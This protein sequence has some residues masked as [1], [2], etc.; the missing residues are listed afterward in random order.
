MPPSALRDRKRER[1]RRALQE[2]AVELF[3]SRGYEATTVADI[4]AA[5][6]V[7]TRT[8]FNYF[9][10]K[11][12][13]LFPE[14]DERVSAAAHAVATRRPDERPVEVL[15]RA[16]RAAGDNPGDHL[17]DNLASRIAVLRAKVSRTVPAVSGRAAHAQLAAQM[18]IA[19]HL[20][21]A[22]PD[23]LDEVEAAALVGAVVG[24]VSGALTALFAHPAGAA[25]PDRL[26]RQI[27]EVTNKVL[28]PWLNP[29]PG[30]TAGDPAASATASAGP[31]GADSERDR[32]D[33]PADSASRP[34]TADDNPAAHQRPGLEPVLA[35]TRDLA[36]D[37][38]NRRRADTRVDAESSVP[39]HPLDDEVGPHAFASGLSGV[40]EAALRAGE[41]DSASADTDEI[42]AEDARAEDDRSG[43]SGSH[44]ARGDTSH[45]LDDATRR[46]IDGAGGNGGARSAGPSNDVRV[47]GYRPAPQLRSAGTE[48]R[49]AQDAEADPMRHGDDSHGTPGARRLGDTEASGVSRE[50]VAPG[51]F[52]AADASPD[53]GQRRDGGE[54]SRS[55][56]AGSGS[57]SVAS[58]ALRRS[59]VVWGT[60]NSGQD[61][62]G[63]E[64]AGRG[65]GQVERS[66]PSAA[67]R[68]HDLAAAV[69][70]AGA[71]IVS[72]RADAP[73]ESGG[74]SGNSPRAEG[75]PSG[76]AAARPSAGAAQPV[77]PAR[78]GSGEFVVQEIA[79]PLPPRPNVVVPAWRSRLHVNSSVFRPISEASARLEYADAGKLYKEAVR[80]MRAGN[81]FGEGEN[82]ET[83]AVDPGSMVDTVGS[84][85]EPEH[86]AEPDGP[87]ND[88]S[89]AAATA[90]DVA[91]TAAD[92]E[93]LV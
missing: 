18:E 1:T 42:R 58:S 33:S 12:E 91:G 19:H 7:G 82:A 75:D 22:F 29:A 73:G 34:R 53:S 87:G 41:S 65:A 55:G 3:E 56:V 74:P 86:A 69:R 13:L 14:P 24:A 49:G 90:S 68:L 16:L 2:A 39:L 31:T 85:T 44:A 51:G 77:A 9:A 62:A 76:D 71:A 78:G 46:G 83:A 5:A 21:A 89:D 59:A 66:G 81:A 30:Q 48:S 23:E 80:N 79:A 70:G 92:D 63:A 84:T 64:A 40:R 26:H 25:D 38:Q 72:P 36:G 88:G 35:D 11:E 43:W 93:V 8:F 45:H 47:D 67:A 54:S 20:R 37:N 27:G 10:S 57:E 15:L 50:S 52:R 60:G 32:P 28:A 4:A 6:E 61:G 17:G